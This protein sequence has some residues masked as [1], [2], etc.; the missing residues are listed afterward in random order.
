MREIEL[1]D[2]LVFSILGYSSFTGIYTCVSGYLN[3]Q[4]RAYYPGGGSDTQIPRIDTTNDCNNYLNS[5][6][7]PKLN[8]YYS[9]FPYPDTFRDIRV[10]STNI[11][12]VIWNSVLIY[13]K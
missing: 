10:L 3:L 11:T 7:E 4:T 12:T 9:D 5:I 8:G 2:I 6:C 13:L 1:R